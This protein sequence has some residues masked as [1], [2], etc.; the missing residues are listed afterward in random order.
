MFPLPYRNRVC[1]VPVNDNLNHLYRRDR[2]EV[3]FNRYSAAA[4]ELRARLLTI[5]FSKQE[6]PI[7]CDRAPRSDCLDPCAPANQTVQSSVCTR[8]S[9]RRIPPD[10][11]EI[12]GAS[13]GR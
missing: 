3:H 11:R 6:R 5:H 10:V 8:C 7:R 1:D 2:R 12:V 9:T 13:G 4:T